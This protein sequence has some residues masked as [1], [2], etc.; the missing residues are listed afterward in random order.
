MHTKTTL[1]T[2]HHSVQI[3][4]DCA[5]K[6]NK[7][8]DKLEERKAVEK[9]QKCVDELVK[10]HE[11]EKKAALSEFEAYK[12]RSEEVLAKIR[13]DILH[14]NTYTHTYTYTHTHAHRS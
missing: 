14:T 6:I 1:N 13:C 3:L 8:K 9:E 7:F 2:Y 5:G 12:K 4:K 11:A 10:Q